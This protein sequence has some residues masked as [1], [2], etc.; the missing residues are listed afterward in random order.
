MKCDIQIRTMKR[1]YMIMIVVLIVG[2]CD[3]RVNMLDE[4]VETDYRY[5]RS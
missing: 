3:I 1:V 4:K 5:R 2:G